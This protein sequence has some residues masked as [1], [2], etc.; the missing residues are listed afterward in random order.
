MAAK[1]EKRSGVLECLIKSIL[2]PV[3]GVI[4]ELDSTLDIYLIVNY[5][6]QA[7]LQL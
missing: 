1:L 6:C 5:K 2:L 4:G 3:V 7:K